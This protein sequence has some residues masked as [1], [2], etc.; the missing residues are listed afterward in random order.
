MLGA[1]L[2]AM[3]SAWEP[4]AAAIEGASPGTRGA[5]AQCGSASRST[6]DSH[7]VA[8]TQDVR[9]SDVRVRQGQGMTR[10][11]RA[12]SAKLQLVQAL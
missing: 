6:P 7:T 9:V 10:A 3:R 11:S 4:L 8:A 1:K 2:A 5:I 12:A